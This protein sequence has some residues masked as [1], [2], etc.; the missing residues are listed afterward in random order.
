VN[1]GARDVAD[2]GHQDAFVQP[3]REQDPLRIDIEVPRTRAHELRIRRIRGHI[4]RLHLL[5]RV[6]DARRAATCV[7]VQVQAQTGTG[8][9]ISL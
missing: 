6:E 1:P 4:R 8:V 2:G 3:V 7:F 9:R 5:D